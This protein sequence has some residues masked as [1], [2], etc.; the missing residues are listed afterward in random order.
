MAFQWTTGIEGE[1]RG[2]ELL[3]LPLLKRA[4][5]PHALAMVN[6]LAEAMTQ[7][8]PV[9]GLDQRQAGPQV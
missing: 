5:D 9:D 1:A 6:A 8:R 7:L 3:F 2:A 4:S